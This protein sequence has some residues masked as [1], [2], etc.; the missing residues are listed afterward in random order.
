VVRYELASDGA[1]TVLT[2]TH[3]G[4]SMRNARGFIPGTHAFLDR[5]AAHLAS[6]EIPVWHERYQQL[7]PAYPAWS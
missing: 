6:D 3:R 7:A 2:F 4:L 1:E 5:L